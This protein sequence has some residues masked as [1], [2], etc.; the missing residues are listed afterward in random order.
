[1]E[2]RKNFSEDN[3]S[4]EKEQT[5]EIVQYVPPSENTKFTYVDSARVL[6]LILSMSAGILYFGFWKGFFAGFC[7]A[8]LPFGILMAIKDKEKQI[9]ATGFLFGVFGVLNGEILSPGWGGLGIGFGIMLGAFI[10]WVNW[11][12]IL[13]N[14]ENNPMI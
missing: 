12:D 13:E 2:Q 6:L 4:T 3:I 8:I 5:F 7:A 14:K 10:I 1:M 9:E 11:K